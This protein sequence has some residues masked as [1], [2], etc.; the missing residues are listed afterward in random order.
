[1]QVHYGVETGGIRD[2]AEAAGVLDG[3]SMEH[4]RQCVQVLC[5]VLI[6]VWR[7]Y[8]EP[9]YIRVLWLRQGISA[10]IWR[11]GTATG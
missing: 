8:G 9:Y 2:A 11:A 3:S 10:L 6:V 4:F 5:S 7:L 1:M